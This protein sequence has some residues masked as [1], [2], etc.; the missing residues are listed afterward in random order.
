M[1]KVNPAQE[2]KSVARVIKI[3]PSTYE[4]M[5]KIAH[6]QCSNFNHLTNVLLEKYI[7]DN[8]KDLEEYKKVF[9]DKLPV[10]PNRWN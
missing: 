8:Q 2:R 10:L 5:L 4:A 9:G 3:K 1:S 7:E 6:M